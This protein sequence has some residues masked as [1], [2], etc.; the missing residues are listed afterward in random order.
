M[1]LFKC[2]TAGITF[3]YDIVNYYIDCSDLLFQ[4]RF[5]HLIHSTKNVLLFFQPNY[6]T[7]IYITRYKTII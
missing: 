1:T 4:I 3:F 7:N 6:K 2:K 5:R